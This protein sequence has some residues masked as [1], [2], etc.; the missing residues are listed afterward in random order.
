MIRRQRLTW[1]EA[2]QR[3]GQS[4]SET[5]EVFSDVSPETGH[6]SR[7]T[8]DVEVGHSILAPSWIGW[9]YIHTPA[10]ASCRT[11]G[12]LAVDVLG[13]CWFPG[14]GGLVEGVGA[15]GH[16]H[17]KCFAGAH[18]FGSVAVGPLDVGG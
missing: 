17:E 15:C 9:A 14:S 18:D 10:M 2:D 5:G 6:P 16:G 11:F 4:R 3:C 7:P 8:L 13:Q 1:P 12:R